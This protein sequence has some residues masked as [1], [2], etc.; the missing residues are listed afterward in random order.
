V[1]YLIYTVRLLVR[2]IR[3]LLKRLRR[4]PEY[5]VFTLEGPYPEMVPPRPPFPRRLLSPKTP[6]LRDLAKQ[7]RYV[8]EDRRVKGV[9]LRLCDVGAATA[10]LQSLR[11]LIAE[12]RGAGKRVVVWSHSYDMARYYVACAADEILLQHVGDVTATGAR[13][14]F[15]FVADALEWIGL[16]AE[17]VQ[18]SPYKTAGDMLTRREMSDEARKMANWLIDDTYEQYIEGIASGRSIAADEAKALIDGGPYP[19]DAAVEVGAIDGLIGEE[20][21]PVHLGTGKKPARLASYGVAKKKLLLPPLRRPGKAIALLRIAGDIIDG[22]SAVPPVRP[23]FRVPLLFSER[24]GDL[25]VVQQ[26]RSLARNKRIGAVVVHVDSGGGSATSSEAMAAALREVAKKK[27]VV[28]SM[29]AVAASGGY[30]VATPGQRLFAQPGTIT[31]SIGVLSGKLVNAGLYEKLLWHREVIS[32]GEHAEMMSTSR[33]FTEEER[34]GLWDRINRIYDVFLDRVMT[35]RDMTR[36][37]VDAIGG[38]RVWTGRQALEH[39]LVDELGGLD[40]AIAVARE[41]AGLH[42]RC[43]TFEV[44]T[45]KKDLAPVGAQAASGLLAYAAD[46]LRHLRSTQVLYICPLVLSEED[47]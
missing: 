9:V 35:S 24:A 4:A 42:R 19:G 10:T 11:D 44:K 5:V 29:G 7:L 47:F 22:R 45:P 26:A 31:G 17:V 14:G 20:D 32:R 8:A 38:G 27:P 13:R 2:W 33:S 34:Q 43:R 30:Y 37:A 1:L 15:V 6:S 46:G 39:G 40:R 18:I 36:D 16:Q 21:L 12:L 23:P 41:K 28:V 25:T 3:N